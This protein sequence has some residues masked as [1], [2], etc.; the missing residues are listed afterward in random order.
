MRNGATPPSTAMAENICG[1]SWFGHC[2]LIPDLSEA[3]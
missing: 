3:L 1:I 2:L